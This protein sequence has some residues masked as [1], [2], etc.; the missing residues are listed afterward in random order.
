VT[1]LRL[2]N[3]RAP[4]Q[5]K[6]AGHEGKAKQKNRA[7]GLTGKSMAMAASPM[8]MGRENTMAK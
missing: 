6:R 1:R 7:E 3:A 8:Q 2:G 4:G 5:G